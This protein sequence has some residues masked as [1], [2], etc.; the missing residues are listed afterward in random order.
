MK[1]RKKKKCKPL[2]V[3]TPVW[4][5]YPAFG[6][7]E[8]RPSVDFSGPRTYALT[9]AHGTLQIRALGWRSVGA[10]QAWMGDV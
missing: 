8:L 4:R 1:N 3:L 5:C 10:W 2:G 9:G 6:P 7:K